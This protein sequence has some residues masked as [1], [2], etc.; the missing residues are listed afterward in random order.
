MTATSAP[1]FPNII[2]LLQ[3]RIRLTHDH[4]YSFPY[5]SSQSYAS[6]LSS[7]Y[8]LCIPPCPHPVGYLLS[9]VA[10]LL[11]ET[12]FTSSSL[13]EEW[14]FNHTV[15]TLTL[16]LGFPNA[17]LAPDSPRALAARSSIFERTARLMRESNNWA[18]LK[19]WR[20]ELYPIY[21]SIHGQRTLLA[22]VERAASPLFGIISYGCHLTAYVRRPGQ[23][24]QLWIPRRAHTKSTYPG[25]L[26]NT[27]AGG[28]A[29][30]ESPWTCIVREAEEEASLPAALMQ[31]RCKAAG[32]VTYLH[33]RDKRA[34]G[35]T[36]LLQPECQ[37]VYDLDMTGYVHPESGKAVVPTP[38]DGEV[39]SFELIG[40]G[41]VRERMGRGEFK[42]NCAVVLLDFLV[43]QGVLT[44]E[45]EQGGGGEYMRVCERLHRRLEAEFGD[46]VGKAGDEEEEEV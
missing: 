42:P 22:S 29:T 12:L 25:L 28:I 16:R 31:E 9:S 26:D 44:A 34:G 40:V 41:E 19:G 15:R 43:R 14:V 21:G 27:V 35:E 5:S 8:K 6:T 46:L 10:L 7:F 18:V 4:L 2:L 32:T 24:M 20:D 11:E 36:G 3:K 1:P 45:D 38:L 13:T 30:G 39:E 17:D 37:F 23:E 33:I